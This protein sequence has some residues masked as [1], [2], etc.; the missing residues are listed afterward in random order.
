M[1]AYNINKSLKESL[2][3]EANAYELD[4]YILLH[5]PIKIQ[6]EREEFVLNNLLPIPET[7]LVQDIFIPSSKDEYSIRLHIYQSKQYN[8]NH[9]LL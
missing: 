2:D 6:D 5:N 9:I 7:I 1:K 8:P 4:P 3:R